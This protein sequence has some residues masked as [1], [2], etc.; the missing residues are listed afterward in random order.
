[1]KKYLAVLAF[2]LAAINIGQ[3]Q[4]SLHF[5]FSALKTDT[6][7]IGNDRFLLLTDKTLPY[8][9]ETSGRPLIPCYNQLIYTS[10][11]GKVKVNYNISAVK[12]EQMA[13]GLRLYPKQPDLMKTGTEQEFVLDTQYYASGDGNDTSV[14]RIKE[15]GIEK[16]RKVYVIQ[17]PAAAYLAKE[18]ILRRF[19]AIDVDIEIDNG[20]NKPTKS[21]AT[22]LKERKMIIV[23]AEEFRQTLQPFIRWK[24]WEGIRVQE[25][26]PSDISG[27]WNANSIKQYLQSLWDN[28]T[29]EEPFADFLLLCGDTAQLSAFHSSAG[30]HITDLYYAD[31][32]SDSI[33]DVLYGRFSAQDTAQMRAIVEKTIAYEKFELQDTAYLN[34][35]L[36]VGGEESERITEINGQINYL[37]AELSGLDTSIY[38]NSSEPSGNANFNAILQRFNDGNGFINYTGH[39]SVSGWHIPSISSSH[40]ASMPSNNRVGFFINNCCKSGDFSANQCFAEALLRGENKGAIGV[41]AASNNTYW[42]GDWIFSV[43]NKSLSLTPSYDSNSLGMYDKMFHSHGE[44]RDNYAVTQ[45]EMMQAGNR[46]VTLALKDYALYYREIYHLFGDPSLM[47]YIGMPQEQNITLPSDIPVGTSALNISAVPYSYVAL[48]VGDSLLTA[49]QA[50]SLGNCYLTL[51]PLNQEGFLRIVITNQSYQPLIDSIVIASSPNPYLGLTN[52]V[53]TKENHNPTSEFVA[54]SLYYLSLDIRNY[55]LQTANDVKVKLSEDGNYQILQQEYNCGDIPSAQTISANE[56]LTFKLQ[57]ALSYN[58]EVILPIEIRTLAMV[59]FDTLKL[60]ASA[61]DLD[62]ANFKLNLANGDTLIEFDVVNEGN[63]ASNSGDVKIYSLNNNAIVLKNGSKPLNALGIGANEHFIFPFSL[64]ETLNDS[65][66]IGFKVEA[67]S[68]PYKTIR[69]FTNI[70]IGGSTEGFE[71]QDFSRYAWS[72]SGKEWIIDTSV[73]YEGRASARS[74]SITDD[75]MSSLL[76]N[77]EALQDDS[78]SFFAKVSSEYLYD[79][80]YFYIDGIEKLTLSGEV[81][82]TR[83]SFAVSAGKHTYQWSYV[84]DYSIGS[85]EDASWIDKVHLPMSATLVNLPQ[86]TKDNNITMYP[87]PASSILNIENLSGKTDIIIMNMQGKV[88]YHQLSTDNNK[89]SI[90]LNNIKSGQYIVCIRSDKALFRKKLIIAK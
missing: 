4:K 53:F 82:W 15:L 6:V 62:I 51:S 84:K 12:D 71:S 31:F 43:G 47:P 14:V 61:P 38:Y 87:N 77:A 10:L 72:H 45:G 57:S 52:A 54:D 65:S 49:K 29:S 33:A 24:T 90:D 74:G 32:T 44:T 9:T 80:F 66:V 81:D 79:K 83:Y 63:R 18:N 73:K 85:G 28:R 89:V 70:I 30:D 20:D 37:K 46:A 75:E 17:V 34:H 50:D 11:D 40:A 64:T 7:S 26:Y 2:C 68:Y 5:D 25:V 16:D 8:T 1:M 78:I 19:G 42:D 86:M 48:S 21:I 76:L 3:A 88:V 22:N 69:N 41:I 35:T 55:G 39:C 67:S 23:S 59:F 36:L 56:A 27:G 58:Q 60:K 13:D